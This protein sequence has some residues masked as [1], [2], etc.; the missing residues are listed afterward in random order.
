M[1]IIILI[2]TIKIKCHFSFK[3]ALRPLD[4]TVWSEILEY[5]SGGY[6]DSDLSLR[7][8]ILRISQLHWN[9]ESSPYCNL[10]KKFSKSSR[11]RVALIGAIR[12]D[13]LRY[14]VVKLKNVEMRDRHQKEK[15][16]NHTDNLM[17]N[18]LLKG[19]RISEECI[20]STSHSQFNFPILSSVTSCEREST[21]ACTGSNTVVSHVS[22]EITVKR[23]NNNN[24]S[25]NNSNIENEKENIQLKSL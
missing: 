19:S 5:Y 2:T 9:L 14:S 6:T 23:N 1:I 18:L 7:A 20:Q 8:L 11:H 17:K 24:N 4:G 12:S 16:E 25:N 13:R 10:G 3:Q 22:T 21:A 15:F